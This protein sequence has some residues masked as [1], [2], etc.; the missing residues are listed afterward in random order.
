MHGFAPGKDV[1]PRDVYLT[2]IDRFCQAAN[3][4]RGGKMFCDL[5]YRLAV[6]MFCFL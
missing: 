5:E 4:L 1:L 3:F 6:I 2:L